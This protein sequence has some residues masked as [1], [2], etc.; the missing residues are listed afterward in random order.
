[1]SCNRDVD[2]D[3]YEDVDEDKDVVVDMSLDV[4][5]TTRYCQQLPM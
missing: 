2:V 4:C 1:M 5:R 3:M